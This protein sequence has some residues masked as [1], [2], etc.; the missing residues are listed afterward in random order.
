MTTLRDRLLKSKIS[1][2]SSNPVP[3]KKNKDEV[4]ISPS[5]DNSIFL[6]LLD[7]NDSKDAIHN[8]I[9]SVE[10]KLNQI[11]QIINNKSYLKNVLME[12]LDTLD[13]PNNETNV[14]ETLK[15]E[16]E[17]ILKD[18][19]IEQ[20]EIL[21]SFKIEQKE[22]H[23][24]NLEKINILNKKIIKLQEELMEK[25]SSMLSKINDN[26]SSINMKLLSK[27]QENFLLNNSSIAELKNCYEEKVVQENNKLKKL[28]TES[29][30]VFINK[31]STFGSENKINVNNELHKIE[32]RIDI[33]NRNLQRN[34]AKEI[35]ENYTMEMSQLNIK[36][37]S[38]KTIQINDNMQNNLHKLKNRVQKIESLLKCS[39]NH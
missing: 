27:I 7:N 1:R 19:K 22:M 28:I 6:K 12:L 16:Q 37:E 29:N 36:L 21:K 10:D 4:V 32:Q 11:V 5:I 2:S 35:M 15:I 26:I 20:K 34:T 24:N 3:Q 14:I 13:E 31:L 38:I 8:R 33:I 9:N 25:N 18:F 23:E 30:D 39:D 17:E